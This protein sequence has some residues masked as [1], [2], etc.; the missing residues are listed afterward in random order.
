MIGV[1]LG[2]VELL[3]LKLVWA[4]Y[5]AVCRLLPAVVSVMLHVPLPLTFMLPVQLSVPSLTWTLPVGALGVLP[6]P[7][8]TWKS[9][10][11]GCRVTAGTGA[12]VVIS[13]RGRASSIVRCTMP[14]ALPSN[15]AA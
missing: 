5:V 3:V 13:A 11:T 8:V 4:R 9:T 10:I 2:C 7:D 12:S 1:G 6:V 14:S 15:P